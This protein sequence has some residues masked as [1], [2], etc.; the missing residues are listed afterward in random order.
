[1]ND[2]T[3]ALLDGLCDKN[4][5]PLLPPTYDGN[6]RRLILNFPVALCPSMD[7]PTEGKKPLLFGNTGYFCVRTV[8]GEGALIRLVERYA[9][10]QCVGFKSFLRV[11]SVLLANQGS[12]SPVKYLQM[13]VSA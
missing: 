7:D 8:N 1:M 6:G 3:L 11:N 10:I 9:E 12:D 5:R 13:G 2:N 4:G